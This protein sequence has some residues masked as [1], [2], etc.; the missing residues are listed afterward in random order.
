MQMRLY[1]FEVEILI[2][3]L[4]ERNSISCSQVR[5]I[6]LLCPVISLSKKYVECM[7]AYL[8]NQYGCF[9]KLYNTFSEYIK[10]CVVFVLV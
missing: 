8:I 9:E 3:F 1:Y 4:S 2:E 6:S 5:F 7:Y 10:D